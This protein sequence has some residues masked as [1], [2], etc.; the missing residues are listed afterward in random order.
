MDERNR[1]LRVAFQ[2]RDATLP[3]AKAHGGR[4]TEAVLSVEQESDQLGSLPVNQ[5]GNKHSLPKL[6]FSSGRL[7]SNARPR[8]RR[9][10]HIAQRQPR[11]ELR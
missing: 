10:A 5:A 4:R 7:T 11:L 8:L 6:V 2:V 1:G 3:Q 9:P